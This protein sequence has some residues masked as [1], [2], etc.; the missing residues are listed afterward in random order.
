MNLTW[1]SG[2]EPTTISNTRSHSLGRLVHVGGRTRRGIANIVR[3]VGSQP[4][5]GRPN[6]V[7]RHEA[8]RQPGE[9]VW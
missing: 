2:Q 4:R 3:L 5:L 9:R 1:C 8:L 7:D 6:L